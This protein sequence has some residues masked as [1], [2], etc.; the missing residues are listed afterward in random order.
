MGLKM[1]NWIFR[2]YPRVYLDIELYRPK[3]R[4]GRAGFF[5][6]KT[7][8][9][10]ASIGVEYSVED[11]EVR[12]WACNKERDILVQINNVL[13]KILG[14]KRPRSTPLIGYNMLALDIPFI[15]LKAWILNLRN[16]K[17]L[18]EKLLRR[19]IHIDL[20]Q[21]ALYAYRGEGLPSYASFQEAVYKARGKTPPEKETGYRVHELYEKGRCNEIERYS[22]GE[23][24][25]LIKLYNLLISG[26][27]VNKD[28]LPSQ[29]LKL[30]D[31][32]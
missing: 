15:I 30:G 8:L 12:T 19:F 28:M 22:R 2:R 24:E 27:E 13:E 18:Q 11:R 9:I 21:L 1:N 29:W 25:E 17:E 10:A 5:S 4:Y 3:T 7:K 16:A 6:R 20:F 23:M 31:M 26:E 32:L 14:N